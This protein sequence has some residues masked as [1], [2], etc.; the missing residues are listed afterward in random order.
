MNG[1]PNKPCSVS[2]PSL[3]VLAPS[4][5]MADNDFNR[6]CASYFHLLC[7]SAFH[8]VGNLPCGVGAALEGCERL[9]QRDGGQNLHSEHGRG[10]YLIN[11]VA[12]EVQF[13]RGCTEIYIRKATNPGR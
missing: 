13:W 2:T 5:D 12:D 6:R 1:S 9:S 7:D 10:I 4:A 3:L 8:A 11:M